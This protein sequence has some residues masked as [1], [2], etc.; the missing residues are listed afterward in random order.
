MLPIFVISGLYILTH[1]S[2]FF[3]TCT[4][5]IVRF[6]IYQSIVTKLTQAFL[7]IYIK[8]AQKP[9]YSREG[10]MLCCKVT[11]TASL[12]SSILIYKVR[13]A[14]SKNLYSETI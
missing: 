1:L 7:Y 12:V 4:P 11:Q 9:R 13:L 5:K 3:L 2:S 10:R 14:R 6:V 8:M